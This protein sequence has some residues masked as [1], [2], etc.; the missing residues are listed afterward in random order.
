M[1]F[2][3]PR[4]LSLPPRRPPPT[5]TTRFIRVVYR[6]EELERTAQLFATELPG[7][8]AAGRIG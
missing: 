8:F 4:P 5:G 1:R 2:Q 7:Q 3:K 6:D